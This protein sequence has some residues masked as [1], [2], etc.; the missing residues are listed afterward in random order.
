MK[1]LIFLPAEDRTGEDLARLI[2]EELTN[3]GLDPNF[4]VGQAYDGCSAMSGQFN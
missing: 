3:L 1:Q 4:M 2:L